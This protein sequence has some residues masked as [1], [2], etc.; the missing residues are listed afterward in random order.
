MCGFQYVYT[1]IES[2]CEIEE[3]VYTGYGIR[4]QNMNT[5]EARS[6]YDV[7]LNKAEV[8]RIVL[9][10]N[11]LCLDPIHIEDVIEDILI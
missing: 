4:V 10:C 11:E 3:R 1:P 6:Y 7:S 9:L 2:T 5:S 8:E